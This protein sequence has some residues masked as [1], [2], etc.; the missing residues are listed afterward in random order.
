MKVPTPLDQVMDGYG[1]EK[2]YFKINIDRLY[3]VHNTDQ[4]NYGTKSV[5]IWESFIYNSTLAKPT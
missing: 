4:S 3:N 1:V 5:N 2:T